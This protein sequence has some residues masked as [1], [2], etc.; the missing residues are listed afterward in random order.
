[1]KFVVVATLFA[2][3]ASAVVPLTFDDVPPTVGNISLLPANSPVKTFY[4]EEGVP[5]SV[6]WNGGEC[7]YRL[8]FSAKIDGGLD[9]ESSEWQDETTYTFPDY[10]P[11]GTQLC[12]TVK[13]SV[14]NMAPT[15]P[16]L[17]IG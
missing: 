5:F 12:L 11:Y 7:P 14:G 16:C 8:I 3:G 2:L 9:E 1:M 6:A 17:W 10:Y 4:S 15:N 13:D